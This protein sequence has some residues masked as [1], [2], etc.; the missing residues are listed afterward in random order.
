MNRY[1][2]T[3]TII[4]IV[5]IVLI[6]GILGFF[7]YKVYT[8]NET[9]KKAEEVVSEFDDNTGN[10]NDT[11]NKEENKPDEENNS[12]NTENLGASIEEILNSFDGNSSSQI[13]NNNNQSGK[14]DTYY[15]GYKVIGTISIPTINIEYP[16]LEEYTSEALKIAIVAQHPNDPANAVNKVGNLVLAGHNLKDDTFFSKIG[17]LTTG[18]KIYIKDTSG[19]KV[20]YQVYNSYE[21]SDSDFTFAT[22]D[23]EGTREITL[24]TCAN[25]AGRRIIVWAREAK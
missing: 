2:N 14:K 15:E 6:V 4:L 12:T 1:G 11:V 20:Q 9:T 16:I 3:L 10:I 17:E 23:T 25:Q 13:N 22:R 18:A 8:S 24:S 21:T 19:T 7:A 5:T